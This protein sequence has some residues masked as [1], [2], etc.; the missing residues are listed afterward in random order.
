[1]FSLNIFKIPVSICQNLVNLR[2]IMPSLSFQLTFCLLD[3]SQK[4]ANLHAILTLDVK[5]DLRN[6]KYQDKDVR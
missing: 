1:M 3:M 4:N 2:L 6:K 5:K